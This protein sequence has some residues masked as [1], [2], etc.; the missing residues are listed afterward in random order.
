MLD[1]YKKVAFGDAGMV[2]LV[3]ELKLDLSEY[4]V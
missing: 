4:L 1:Y 3:C 2:Y